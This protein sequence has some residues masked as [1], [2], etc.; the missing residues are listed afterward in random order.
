MKMSDYRWMVDALF[1]MAAF[2]EKNELQKSHDSL[3]NSLVEVIIEIGAA[4][5]IEEEKLLGV[6]PSRDNFVALPV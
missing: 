3:I 6:G 1:D 2:A 5:H 4:D